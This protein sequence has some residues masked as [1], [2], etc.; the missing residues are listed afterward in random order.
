MEFAAVVGARLSCCRLHSPAQTG[1]AGRQ[2]LNAE[3]KKRKNGKRKTE[4]GKRKTEN[5]KRKKG[6]TAT[7]LALPF[8]VVVAVC[9]FPPSLRRPQVGR[10][11]GGSGR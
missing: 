6:N 8:V 3:R 2:M 5:G 7:Q 11:K 10:G 1:A 9:R 4:N